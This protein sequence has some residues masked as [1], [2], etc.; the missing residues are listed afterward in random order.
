MGSFEP[1]QYRWGEP[2]AQDVGTYQDQV[3]DGLG[4]CIPIAAEVHRGDYEQRSG[5]HN[6]WGE[7]GFGQ[8]NYSAAAQNNYA[9]EQPDTGTSQK[10]LHFWM[11][12]KSNGKQTSRWFDLGAEGG[13]ASGSSISDEAESCWLRDVTG[14]WFLFNAHDTTETRDCYARVEQVA[15]RYV[16]EDAKIRQIKLTEKRGN[17]SNGN[18]HRGPSKIVY[19]YELN[20][21]DRALVVNNRYRLLGCRIQL[22]LRRG[23]IGTTTDTV[24]AGVTGLRFS[25]GDSQ[26]PAPPRRVLVG[27]HT[28]KWKDFDDSKLQLQV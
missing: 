2:Y 26:T 1:L 23:A 6:W 7:S 24:Q 22:Q 16:D 28:C 8:D 11:Q 25:L 9:F 14:L 10:G 13:K 12:T 21:S 5:G 27:H 19:G 15:L 4:G 18:G 17:I 3:K 20:S